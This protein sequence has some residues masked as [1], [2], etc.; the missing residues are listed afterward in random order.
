MRLR[1]IEVKGMAMSKVEE[2][3]RFSLV[4]GFLGGICY[5]AFFGQNK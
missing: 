2:K 3:M 4:G 5:R 1:N